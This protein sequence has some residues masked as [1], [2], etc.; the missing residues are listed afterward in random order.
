MQPDGNFV[1]YIHDVSYWSTQTSRSP[2]PHYHLTQ[3]SDGNLVLYTSSNQAVWWSSGFNSN[4]PRTTLQG[5][6]RLVTYVG[7][8]TPVWWT[9]IPATTTVG[10]YAYPSASRAIADGWTQIGVHGALG[11]H[12]SPWVDFPSGADRDTGLA[13]QTSGRNIVW[14]SYWTVSGPQGGSC[15]GNAVLPAGGV[16]NEGSSLSVGSFTAVLQHD[17]NFVLYNAGR[18]LWA[19]W[20]VGKGGKTLVMQNDGNLVLYRPDGTPVWWT[21]T[22]GA[23]S[24]LVL[25]CDGNMVIYNSAGVPKWSTNTAV[26]SG[27]PQKYHDIGFTA[28]QQVARWIDGYGL[29]IKPNFVTLDPEGFPDKHSGLDAGGSAQWVSMMA[30][31]SEGIRSIDSSLT[32][33]FYA[34]QSEY[35]SFNLRA[36]AMPFFLAVAFGGDNTTLTPPRRLGGVDGSNIKGVVAFYEGPS[37]D[38]QCSTVKSAAATIANWGYAYNTLQFNKGLACHA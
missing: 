36:I 24:S 5:D 16:L 37:N 8:A 9:P 18:V 29:R 30:G 4:N 26:S 33:A 6:G 35:L 38:L 1:L 23:K 27:T 22:Q 31:W 14:N 20:T 34:T 28:G 25:Q 11:T 15:K 32:P 3:Q 12:D 2:N 17:G 13:I 21:S 19:T 7:S 10:V